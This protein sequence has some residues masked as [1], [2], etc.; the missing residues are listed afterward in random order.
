MLG[1]VQVEFMERCAAIDGAA[2]GEG[3]FSP[4]PAIWVGK[5][6]IAHFDDEQ[7][8][9]VRLTKAVIRERRRELQADPRVSLRRGGADWI[10]VRTQS[11]SDLRL[12]T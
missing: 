8:L 9:D 1:L 2:L 7:S 6:E 4:G 11:E 5:R 12:S 10:E 3:A